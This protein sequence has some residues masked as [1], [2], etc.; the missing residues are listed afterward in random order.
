VIKAIEA[1]GEQGKKQFSTIP[2]ANFDQGESCKFLLRSEQTDP[3]TGHRCLARVIPM[4]GEAVL[5]APKVFPQEFKSRAL[6]RR[7]AAVLTTGRPL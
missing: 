3:D 2:E 6:A 4:S 1:P 5:T 7:F